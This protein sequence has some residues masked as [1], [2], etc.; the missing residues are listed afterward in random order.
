MTQPVEKA[1]G[2][3]WYALA[4]LMFVY[5]LNFLDRQIV[6]ILLP[7]IKA[8]MVF[9]DLQLSLLS[10]TPFVIFYTILGIP[11]GRFS[12]KCRA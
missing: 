11:F 7:G 9:T 2:Y 12:D 8:E 1:S 4:L 10:G 5:I 6:Y 3:A